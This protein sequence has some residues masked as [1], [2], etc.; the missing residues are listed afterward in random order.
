M[1]TTIKNAWTA[2]L[3][4][5]EYEQVQGALR[6]RSHDHDHEILGYCCLGVL[7]DVLIEDDLRVDL[8]LAWA[9]DSQVGFR[10]PDYDAED[11][12]SQGLRATEGGD[13]GPWLRAVLGV[14]S[15]D[16]AELVHMNDLGGDDFFEIADWIDANL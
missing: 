15:A 1:D 6:A 4:G 12:T 16:E 2:A 13:L 10:N 5:G 11:P 9:S 8:Q 3:R 7:I 14:S